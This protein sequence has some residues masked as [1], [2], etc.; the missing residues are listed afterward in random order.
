MLFLQTSEKFIVCWG[1]VCARFPDY[2]SINKIALHAFSG[3]HTYKAINAVSV[4]ICVGTVPVNELDPSA[5]WGRS[6]GVWR[7]HESVVSPIS[8]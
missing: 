1:S 4:A 5:L 2:M 6:G 8:T 3:C 7:Q